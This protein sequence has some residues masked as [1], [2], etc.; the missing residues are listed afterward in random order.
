MCFI[1]SP[2]DE[3][4]LSAKITGNMT[5]GCV[6][7]ISS[8]AHISEIEI[9][10]LDGTS[11]TRSFPIVSGIPGGGSADFAPQVCTLVHLGTGLRGPA[12][13]GRL[14]LPFTSEGSQTA[15]LIDASVLS[16]M[17]TAWSDFLDNMATDGYSWAVLSESQSDAALV[18]DVVVKQRVATQR[19]RNST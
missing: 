7:S 10:K 1:G 6:A 17:Q 9:I 2:G 14:Y 3:A 11:G 16:A 18:T 5:A 19:R 4:D 8:N 13:R 15:G 12:R